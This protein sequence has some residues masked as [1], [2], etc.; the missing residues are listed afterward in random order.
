MKEDLN[1]TQHQILTQ[2]D[3]LDNFVT[4]LYYFSTLLETLKKDF[5]NHLTDL[6]RLKNNKKITTEEYQTNLKILKNLYKSKMME[7]KQNILKMADL[8]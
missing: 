4:D 2:E 3:N 5:K 7:L 1:S 6:T 8:W